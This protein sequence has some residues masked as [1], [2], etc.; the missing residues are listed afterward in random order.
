[1][2]DHSPHEHV[3]TNTQEVLRA[4]IDRTKY[5]NSIQSCPET[6]D[7]IWFLR[8]ALYLYEVRAYRRK[9]DKLNQRSGLHESI[10]NVNTYRDGFSDIP[11][12]SATIEDYPIGRDGHIL[13]R[14]KNQ[15]VP[16]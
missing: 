5:L 6:E 12:D 3:G 4:L 1:M 10:A 9:Q 8:Q 15:M 16:T 7:A 13:A 11:F 14:V 2:I